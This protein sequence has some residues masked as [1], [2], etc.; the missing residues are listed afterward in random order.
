MARARA[1]GARLV[2]GVLSDA[3]AR[4][5]GRPT[6]MTLS[7]RAAVLEAC[8]YVDEVISAPPACP[9]EAFLREHAID[10]VCLVD[11]YGS[12]ERKAAFAALRQSG[13]TISLAAPDEIS[14]AALRERL[15]RIDQASS[16]RAAAAVSPGHAEAGAELGKKL[17]S[18][19]ADQQLMLD[20]L[21]VIASVSLRQRWLLPDEVRTDSAWIRYLRT[22]LNETF[23]VDKVRADRPLEMAADLS[24]I[25]RAG[26]DS[27][28]FVLIGGQAVSLGFALA[29]EP[30]LDVSVLQTGVG[31]GLA[32]PE[33][34][35][36][37]R[38]PKVITCAADEMYWACP[39]CDTLA[40]LGQF[41][42]SL[43]LNY[44]GGRLPKLFHISQKVRDRVLFTVELSGA[45]GRHWE[46]RDAAR[47]V[48]TDAFVRSV[49]HEAGFFEA[50]DLATV[51][52]GVPTD[53]SLNPPR[54]SRF[55]YR[56][57]LQHGPSFR[58]LDGRP[59]ESIPLL[60]E[61]S[62][63]TRWYMARKGV[64]GPG[65]GMAADA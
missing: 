48:Y 61:N 12:D 64:I 37:P 2:V 47:Y 27:R 39:P 60:A 54:V 7:E 6:V 56:E 41:H 52:D 50:V 14:L 44:D 59:A 24:L 5:F 57:K 22:T 31:S 30:R 36:A 9:D 29:A 28:S 10:L 18:I 40:V 11:D 51:I 55:S 43:L 13:R 23:D 4:R 15:D 20:T 16:D 1:R 17:D 34:G 3:D 33:E 42:S 65:E 46:T 49:L 63:I 25:R 26:G 38:A 19:A 53:Q 58:Y 35:T 21:G 62:R 32:F 8:R 45:S